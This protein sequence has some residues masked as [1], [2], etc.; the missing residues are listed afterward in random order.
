[1]NRL[2]EDEGQPSNETHVLLVRA[3]TEWTDSEDNAEKLLRQC[4]DYFRN[5][6][7]L[8][9]YIRER[10]LTLANEDTTEKLQIYFEITFEKET[11]AFISRGWDESGFR[12]GQVLNISKS[13]ELELRKHPK[14]ISHFL[15]SNGVAITADE[16]E[17]KGLHYLNLTINIPDAGFNRE[18]LLDALTVLTACVTR[19]KGIIP[20][21]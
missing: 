7:L 3:A 12:L 18:T 5:K 4:A 2:E 8:R 14:E 20:C 10:G 9:R 15:A 17:A 19:I 6:R 16:D 21:E 1:M 11:L 13:H